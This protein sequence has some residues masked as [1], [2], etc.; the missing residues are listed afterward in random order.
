[1]ETILDWAQAA[2]MKTGRE[3]KTSLI[4]IS[5]LHMVSTVYLCQLLQKKVFL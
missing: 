3:V 5:G 4:G 2:G 1:M